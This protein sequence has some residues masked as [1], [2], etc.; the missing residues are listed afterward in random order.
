[1]KFLYKNFFK[2]N[3]PHFLNLCFVILKRYQKLAL[4]KTPQDDPIEPFAVFH[5]KVNDYKQPK[6]TRQEIS[7]FTPFCLLTFRIFFPQNGS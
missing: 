6:T 1:M 3:L 4:K 2:R 7:L 5:K